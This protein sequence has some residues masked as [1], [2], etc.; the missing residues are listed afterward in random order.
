MPSCSLTVHGTGAHEVFSAIK[1]GRAE[2]VF[3]G[4]AM[5]R[6]MSSVHTW[7]FINEGSDGRCFCNSNKTP[8]DCFSNA[9][10]RTIAK[11]TKRGITRVR[12]RD[13]VRPFN[14]WGSNRDQRWARFS[15]TGPQ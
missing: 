9:Q 4:E 6:I 3:P 7:I 2:N 11:T 5:T 14:Q 12:R 8:S 10:Q 13:I 1:L 15:W